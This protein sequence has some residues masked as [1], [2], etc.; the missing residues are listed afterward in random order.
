MLFSWF[1]MRP[2]VIT[3]FTDSKHLTH[4]Q[5]DIGADIFV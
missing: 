2:F 3:A 1:F 5:H 4:L